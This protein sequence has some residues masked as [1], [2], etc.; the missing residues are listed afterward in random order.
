[1]K[2]GVVKM[3]EK[4]VNTRLITFLVIL[5]LVIFVFLCVYLVKK[6]VD[7]KYQ[8]ASKDACDITNRVVSGDNE[9]EIFH[10][11]L[12]VS[13]PKLLSYFYKAKKITNS[14]VSNDEKMLAAI[15]NIGF[16][17]DYNN[18]N[19]KSGC[20]FSESIVNNMVQKIFGTNSS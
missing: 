12:A 10:N 14:D 15:Y 4:R 17:N 11:Y 2:I 7:K 18:D 9:A 20:L 3:D 19:L 6:N 1:M 5:V 13:D 8:I 16:Y